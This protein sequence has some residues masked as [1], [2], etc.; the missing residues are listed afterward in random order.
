MR[1]RWVLWAAAIS[2]CAA[3][4]PKQN[5]FANDP[6]A[7]KDGRPLF[8]LMCSPCHGIHAEGGRGPDLTRGTYSVGD[9]DADLYDVIANGAQG[10]EMADFLG[11]IGEE[12]VW[13]L[14]SYIRSV[15]RK[16]V[17]KV[18]GDPQKGE[19]LFWEKGQCGQCHMVRGRGGRMGPDLTSAGRARS[20]AYLRE[21][22]LEPN[23][24]ITP[25]YYTVRVVTRDGTTITG[26]QRGFDNFSAQLM[27]VN[28]HYYSFQK[29][30]VASIK[31]EYRS[32]MPDTYRSL[33]SDAEL[34][35]LLAYL[36][37]LRGEVKR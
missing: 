12:N 10:T 37:S 24:D 11:R 29:S 19:K 15:S 35:D 8:R 16:D 25:G 5:P 26:A 34:N 28:D 3:Q 21:S 30:D 7:A 6:Q 13:R 31:R 36:A 32:M 14:V 18:A 9:T 22:V 27:D 1:T 4:Q 23:A 33:F 20:L 2:L 17:E